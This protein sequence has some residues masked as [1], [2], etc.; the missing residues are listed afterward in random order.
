[1]KRGSSEL[2]LHRSSMTIYSTSLTVLPCYPSWNRDSTAKSNQT[3]QCKGGNEWFHVCDWMLTREE[4][5]EL[6]LNWSGSVILQCGLAPYMRARRHLSGRRDTSK[7]EWFKAAESFPRALHRSPSADST[8]ISNTFQI[9]PFFS[10]FVWFFFLFGFVSFSLVFVWFAFVLYLG[11]ERNGIGYWRCENP[12]VVAVVVGRGAGLRL[13]I[14][15]VGGE[16]WEFHVSQLSGFVSGWDAMSLRVQRLSMGRNTDRVPGFQP[17]AGLLRRVSRFKSTAS[18]ATG[19]H[20]ICLPFMMRFWWI[21]WLISLD[22]MF[23]T[24]AYRIS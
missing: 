17:G 10:Y 13:R 22:W 18:M 6:R 4:T 14:Q 5:D 16:N 20:E 1:M 23:V 3:S 15:L 11:R 8:N 9:P 7:D 19:C 24:V 2:K 12:Q 21:S